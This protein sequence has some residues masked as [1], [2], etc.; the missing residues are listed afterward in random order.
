MTVKDKWIP[1]TASAVILALGGV[2]LFKVAD[3]LWPLALPDQK[4]SFSSVV[5]DRDGQPM[6]AFADKKGIWRYQISLR[7]ISP[8]FIEALLTYEDRYFYRHPGVNPLSILRAAKQ[9]LI[10]G[11]IISGGSTLT[12]QVARILHPH[13]RTIGGKLQQI[14]RALQLE[15]HFS[16]SEI[17]EFYVNYAPFGG[18]VEGV[19]AASYQYLQKPASELRH[20]EA[21]MLA[22]LPQAPSRLRPDRHPN[23]AE[24]ARNKVLDRIAKFG[25]WPLEQ[26]IRA[27]KERI[28]VWDLERPM[29]APLLSRRLVTELPDRRVIHTTI[30]RDIQQSL[31]ELVQGYAER[32]GGRISAALMAVDNRSKEV[33]AYIGSSNFSDQ[34]RSGYIDMVSVLRSPGSTLKPFLYG[35]SLDDGLIHSQ[36]LM[37]D[38]PRVL[39]HYRPGNFSKHYIGPVSASEALQR[40]LNVPFVQLI[41][42]FGAER[43]VNRL[44]H[45]RHPLAIPPGK[46]SAA[47][48]LGGAGTSLEHLVSLYS[49]FANQGKIYELIKVKGQPRSPARRLL[50]PEAAWI[51]AK[52]LQGL[53]LPRGFDFGLSNAKRPNVTWKTGTSWG[54]RDVWAVGVTPEHT[55]GVWLGHPSGKPMKNALGMSTAGPLLFRAFSVLGASRESFP[56]PLKVRQSNICW[57]GGRDISA[58]YGRCDIQHVAYTIDGL[59]PPTLRPEYGAE[60]HQDFERILV[61]IKNKRRVLRN[62][63]HNPT[64]MQDYTVWPLSLEP[65]LRPEFKRLNRIPSF[66]TQCTS[67]PVSHDNLRLVGMDYGQVFHLLDT[68]PISVTLRAEG[69]NP[70]VAWYLDGKV[71]SANKQTI[72]VK[73]NTSMKGKHEIIAVDVEG[74]IG[75]VKF[76]VL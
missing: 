51:T 67:L 56:Q 25:V 36:S 28:R 37:A 59:T 21:A 18:T 57:P 45:V 65:W 22:I 1:Y 44:R 19:Q 8:R 42:A 70:N 40:S 10:S 75:R 5:L 49:G 13:P 35:L 33:L 54:H 69:K 23:R 9:N 29:V 48:I 72:T 60:F 20:S 32:Q 64:Q 2:L 58:S 17:L 71:L 50:S 43:F 11:R 34:N 68:A 38:I 61:D 66:D 4:G 39:G 16:K 14:Y 52:T 27:K 41:E 15:W 47:V 76:S 73:I 74:A 24:F 6:R 12:M 7:E 3:F 55:I 63:A 62:C 26:V 53:Q 31:A 46:T 30:N